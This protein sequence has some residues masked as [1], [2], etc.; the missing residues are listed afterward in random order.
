M[1]VARWEIIVAKVGNDRS[2]VGNNLTLKVLLTNSWEVGKF[3]CLMMWRKPLMARAECERLSLHDILL[4][5][6]FL[7]ACKWMIAP[8]S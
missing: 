2:W 8:C 5:F 7:L 3:H 6:G 4:S 1:I